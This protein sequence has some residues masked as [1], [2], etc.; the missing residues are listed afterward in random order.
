MDEG[1]VVNSRAHVPKN[2]KN[3]NN[4]KSSSDNHEYYGCSHPRYKA[5]CSVTSKEQVIEMN[6]MLR[7][8]AIVNNE[9]FTEKEEHIGNKCIANNLCKRLYRFFAWIK[10]GELADYVAEKNQER[11]T[12]CK[13]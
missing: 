10:L 12:C 7:N 8:L 3:S 9:S 4:K 1:S 13:R 2:K 6:C 5:V 11:R